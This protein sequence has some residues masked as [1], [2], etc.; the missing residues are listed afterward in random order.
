[1]M[2]YNSTTNQIESYGNGAWGVVGGGS[3]GALILDQTM[4]QTIINGTPLMDETPTGAADIKSL[5]NKE[6]VD[7]A[8]TSL[9]A[10]YYMYD[11]V[12][13]TG[14]KLCY[15]D[16][17][18]DAEVYDEYSG[19]TDGQYLGGWISAPDQAP[20]KLLKGVYDWFIALEKTVGKQSLRVYWELY[21]RKSDNSEVLIAI[22]SLSNEIDGRSTYIVPLQLNEDYL[23][24]ANSRIVG[25]LYAS[26]SG[27]GNAPTIRI[28]YQGNTSSR[29]EIPANTEIFK[30]IFVPYTGAVQDV[31]LGSYDLTTTGDITAGNLNISNWDTYEE[32]SKSV[33][34]LEKA[35]DA[36]GVPKNTQAI[37][38]AVQSFPSVTDLAK[39]GYKKLLPKRLPHQSWVKLIMAVRK[40]PKTLAPK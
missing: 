37:I 9:G 40:I 26:I 5:V 7:L 27:G 8:V 17:S 1:M 21:E 39:D 13:S 6:Y 38:G 31:D 18:S 32:F 22:S 19:L 4:P 29:W 11:D 10:A 28:Y 2:I 23:P 36:A 30:N 12:D 20:Q 15:L 16:P 33:P 14:Y 35:M 3:S 24:D 25:K 34:I